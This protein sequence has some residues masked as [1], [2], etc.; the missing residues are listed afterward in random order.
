MS[1]VGKLFGDIIPEIAS[2]T[3]SDIPKM[4]EAPPVKDQHLINLA[5]KESNLPPAE[6]SRLTQIPGTTPTYEK[7]YKLL[8]EM[9]VPS[10]RLDFGAGLGIGAKKVGADTYEPFPP[11][12]FTPDF[13]NP[14]DIP[15][16]SYSAVTNL[17]VLNVVPKGIRD[18]IVQN[19]GRILKPEGTA[20]ITTR[21]KD[22]MTAKGVP[23]HEPMSMIIGTGDKARYQKGF[24]PKE[25][26]QYVKETLGSGF[27]VEPLKLG[28]AGVKIKKL[29]EQVV[30]VNASTLPQ[31][32]EGM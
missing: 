27:A 14:A 29:P 17:N 9:G 22:V 10:D 30:D 6:N 18:E 26:Q 21:G 2:K 25:L 12:G 19:I 32:L 5:V 13:S 20:I 4:F 31:P 16:N 28:Q 15:D 7:A 8:D 3:A 23:G 1:I 24:T 11:K